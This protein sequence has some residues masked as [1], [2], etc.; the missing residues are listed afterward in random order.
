MK[1]KILSLLGVCYVTFALLMATGGSITTINRASLVPRPQ[2]SVAQE[3]KRS[4]GHCERLPG[5]K[6]STEIPEGNP[7]QRMRHR[8]LPMQAKLTQ[9]ISGET[10][11]AI[12]Q[13]DRTKNFLPNCLILWTAEWCSS[14]KKMYPIVESLREEGYAVYVLDYDENRALGRKMGVKSLPTSII[15]ENREEVKRHVGIVS[16]DKLLETLKKNEEPEYDIW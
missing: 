11:A 12:V 13:E 10:V 7:A 14:C 8:W 16:E 4:D 9:Q 1:G 6:G 15:W 2:D 5:L 3:D